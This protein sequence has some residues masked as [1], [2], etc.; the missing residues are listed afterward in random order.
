MDGHR[1]P[2]WRACGVNM[3]FGG[4]SAAVWGL[5]LAVV[6]I[7]LAL[8]A[9]SAGG[10]SE[11]GG[12]LALTGAVGIGI[13]VMMMR[14]GTL[15]AGGFTLAV[16]AAIQG[17]GWAP[18]GAHAPFESLA[19]SLALAA[20]FSA[21]V[22]GR[23]FEIA[24]TRAHL[25]RAF[26]DALPV[27]AL[28]SIARDPDLLKTEGEQRT[29][30]CL[31]CGVR[32]YEALGESFAGNPAGLTRMI[33]SVMTPLVDIALA[34]G[35]MVDCVTGAGFIAYW[36]A[37][38][39]DPEHALHACEAAGRMV[40]ALAAA[41]TSVTIGIGLA[42][43]LAIVGGLG[44][45]GRMAYCVAGPCK[46]LAEQLLAQSAQYGMAVV[47]S[48]QTRKLA[49]SGHAFLEVDAI[50]SEPREEPL[51]VF[52]ML[53]N[54]AFRASP[55]FRALATFHERIFEAL[56][57][58]QWADARERIEQCRKLSGANQPLYDLYLDRIRH[59]ED[60]PPAADWDGVFRA[61]L[62]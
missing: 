16:I 5:P 13:A 21:G 58:Q 20:I 62:N 40:E 32:N 47:A 52:A 55:K 3:K 19:P 29:L 51:S 9:G 18:F 14:K 7:A 28:D 44:A 33:G 31:A 30:S 26:A 34:S 36:N 2:L 27:S 35:A 15:W 12:G 59:L 57:A 1:L 39:V 48:D 4:T 46:R 50:A 41:S 25:R 49:G 37:P 60:N 42:T 23:R 11:H 17:Y 45:R 56:R 6:I 54:S 22:A 24:R 8:I 10:V 43:D 53:G 61:A 38:L